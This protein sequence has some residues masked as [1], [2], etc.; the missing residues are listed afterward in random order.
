MKGPDLYF[1]QEQG[2]KKADIPEDEAEGDD[3]DDSQEEPEV[4]EA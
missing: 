4:A 3:V 2:G 1:K